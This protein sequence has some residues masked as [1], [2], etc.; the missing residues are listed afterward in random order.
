[1]RGWRG[2]AAAAVMLS[3]WAAACGR[4]A[5]PGG[6]PG[7]GGG[8]A[9]PVRLSIATGGT[10]GV[11]Y[12]LGGG[13][14]Q[15]LSKHIE[16][17]EATAEVTE[18]SVANMQL[19]AQRS[20]DIAFTLVDTAFD[21]ARGQGKFSAPL[22]IA[23]LAAIHTNATHI[24]TL[25]DSGI[26]TVA[27]LRG[28][29]VSTGAPNS[30]TEVIAERI[31]RAAGIDPDRDITRE[32]LSLKESADALKDRKIDAFFWS[33]G[34]PTAGV[35]ELGASPNVTIRLIAHGELVEALRAQYGPLYVATE[36][37]AGVYPDVDQ[38]VTVSAVPNLLVVHRDMPEDLAY[39]ITRVLFEHLDELKAVHEAAEQI[40]PRLAATASPV[41]YH[42]GAIRYYKEV[43]VWPGP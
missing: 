5:E 11:Y 4:P 10:S 17:V 40:E 3:L 2:W 7:A 38:P 19:L 18:A 15:L 21:A 20:A 8:Q 25:A 16:G 30:G 6:T 39:R 42:P 31:L 43:G 22:P 24:V 32:R 37:P 1:M 13:L 23:T 33:G 29:R 14:A 26:Q 27:D 12:V 41:E 9:Q 34:I 28:R 36:I 35:T